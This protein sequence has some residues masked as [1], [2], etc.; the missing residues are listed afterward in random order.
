M[1]SHVSRIFQFV[2]GNAGA[3]FVLLALVIAVTSIPAFAQGGVWHV[4]GQ[5]SIARLSLGSDSRAVEVGVARVSGKVAFD[6][7]DPADPVVSLNITPDSDPGADYSQISFK[8]KRSE[9]SSD[10][11]LAVVGDLSLTRVERSVTLDA[12]EGYYGA[13]YGAPVVHTDTREVTLVFPGASLPGSQTGAIELSAATHISRERFPQLLTALAASN[14]P[15]VVVEDQNCAMPATVGE[16]YSGAICTGTP[17]ATAANSVAPAI[18]GGGEGYY[19]FESAIVPDRSQA[20]IAFDLKL[21]QQATSA[22]SAASATAETAG[23]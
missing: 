3:A 19:G 18:G 17:A 8:S 23:N 4:D 22:P 9:M 7:N 16:D 10:G 20:T 6:S 14:W 21:T 13:E 11:K 1:R 15:N 2:T 12:N 5:H